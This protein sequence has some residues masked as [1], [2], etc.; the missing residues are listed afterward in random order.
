MT[1][2]TGAETYIVF[3]SASGTRLQACVRNHSQTSASQTSGRRR[4]VLENSRAR[5]CNMK[6]VFDDA[7]QSWHAASDVVEQA[8]IETIF[9]ALEGRRLDGVLERSSRAAQ[10]H[11]DSTLSERNSIL[12]SVLLHS[13]D[14]EIVAKEYESELKSGGDQR[15]VVQSLHKAIRLADELPAISPRAP[16]VFGFESMHGGSGEELSHDAIALLSRLLRAVAFHSAHGN[17]GVN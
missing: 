1:G 11:I 6:A 12:N 14:K 8:A 10:E 5:N 15:H 7:H 13:R 17:I 2:Q 4:L 16:Q 9:S 3:V